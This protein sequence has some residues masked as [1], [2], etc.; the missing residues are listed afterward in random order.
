MSPNNNKKNIRR[1]KTLTNVE[2]TPEEVVARRIS[3][4]AASN[5]PPPGGANQT[6][7]PLRPTHIRSYSEPK[8]TIEEITNINLED[9]E[10]KDGKEDRKDDGTDH[11]KQ[12]AH[13]TGAES[14]SRDSVLFVC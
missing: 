11:L 1:G 3:H 10:D 14:L 13:H 9:A 7:K 2:A 5:S 6:Q 8:D 4:I 12:R